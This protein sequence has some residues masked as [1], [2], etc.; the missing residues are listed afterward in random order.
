[1]ERLKWIGNHHTV[2]LGCRAGDDKTQRTLAKVVIAKVTAP[3]IN[4]SPWCRSLQAVRCSRLNAPT[5]QF[6]SK[7]L[8]FKVKV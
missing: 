1:M 4:I 6:Q 8:N 7:I 2:S 5:V 3:L